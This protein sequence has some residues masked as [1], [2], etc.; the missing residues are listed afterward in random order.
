[1]G[2]K[3]AA[4]SSRSAAKLSTAN[5]SQSPSS[6]P[7]LN[8]STVSVAQSNLSGGS[9]QLS[10]QGNRIMDSSST[11]FASSVGFGSANGFGN[12]SVYDNLSP[13]LSLVLKKMNKRDS[14]TKLK[15]IEELIS[16]IEREPEL[17]TELITPWVSLYLQL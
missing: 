12:T 17:V 16:L 13:N 14:L 10:Y 4:S 9:V 1:M 15:A 8:S 7:S 11:G 3:Q 5:N 6:N 2:K